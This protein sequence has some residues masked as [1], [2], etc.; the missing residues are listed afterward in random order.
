M[1]KENIEKI[2]KSVKAQTKEDH[3]AYLTDTRRNSDIVR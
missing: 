2:K 1:K 3:T